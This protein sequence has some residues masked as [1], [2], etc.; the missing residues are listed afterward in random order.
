MDHV[1]TVAQS[2]DLHS[3]AFEQPGALSVTAVGLRKM[4]CTPERVLE[5]LGFLQM[6]HSPNS[7][8]GAY[9]GVT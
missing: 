7:L 5:D 9:V 2:S 1:H 6:S 8:Q 4:G 3:Q